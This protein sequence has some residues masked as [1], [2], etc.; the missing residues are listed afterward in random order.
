MGGDSTSAAIYLQEIGGVEATTTVGEVLSNSAADLTTSLRSQDATAGLR[1]LQRG[2][3]VALLETAATAMG[4]PCP[5]LRQVKRSDLAGSKRKLSTIIDQGL[6]AEISSMQEG[7]V[8]SPLQN[9]D[10]GNGG[11]PWPHEA[12]SPEQLQAVK[13]V[14]NVDRAPYTDFAV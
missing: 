7:A 11:L 6:D 9:F 4:A 13:E 2:T 12:P 3:V 14:L 5:D 1:P 10:Q 8:R